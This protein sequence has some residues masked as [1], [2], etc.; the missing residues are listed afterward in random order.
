MFY[1]HFSF[2]LDRSIWVWIVW[3]L[4]SAKRFNHAN[5]QVRICYLS[6]GI[7]SMVTYWSLFASRNSDHSISSHPCEISD[8]LS[9]RLVISLAY[10]RVLR[11][12]KG[13][14]QSVKSKGFS[15]NQ[16][17]NHTN[18]KLFLLSNGSYTGVSNNS[19]GHTGSKSGKTT[20]ESGSQVGK[21]G[22]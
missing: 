20:A 9:L 10:E 14:N 1:K 16:D 11:Q 22:V 6:S 7:S 13:N 15:E 8:R 12:N 21:S 5:L 4:Q 3:N 2:Q 19:N 17:Q 18:K